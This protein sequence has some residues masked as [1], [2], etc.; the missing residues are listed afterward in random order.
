MTVVMDWS[1]V[2]MMPVCITVLSWRLSN[3]LAG[4]F[5]LEAFKET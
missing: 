3:T 4:L 1:V 5:C 2:K